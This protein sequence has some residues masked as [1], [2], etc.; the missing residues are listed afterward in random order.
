MQG[1]SSV[2]V[3]RS[4][5][6]Y[7]TGRQYFRQACLAPIVISSGSMAHR[8]SRHA[9]PSACNLGRASD[10][11]PA[12]RPSGPHRLR[13]MPCAV[14]RAV[15]HCGECP[16]GRRGRASQVWVRNPLVLGK[17]GLLLDQA[18]AFQAGRLEYPSICATFARLRA[19]QP[20]PCA[21]D[22]SGSVNDDRWRALCLS[23]HRAAGHVDERVG[24]DSPLSSLPFGTARESRDR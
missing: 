16:K 4:A 3:C 9:G 12:P 10:I 2:P 23:A 6:P 20:I 1:Q 19:N 5:D 24:S 15:P 11:A 17:I 13:V 18:G 22:G 7:A 8:D 14:T 21:F